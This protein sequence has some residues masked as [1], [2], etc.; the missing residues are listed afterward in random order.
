[1]GF[2]PYGAE[3]VLP[4]D[5]EDPPS[6]FSFMV[7]IESLLVASGADDG[8]LAGLFEQVDCVC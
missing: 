2:T 6:N 1:M 3:A 8:H 7:P 4:S 5:L